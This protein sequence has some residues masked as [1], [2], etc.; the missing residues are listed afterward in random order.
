MSCWRCSNAHVCAC[1]PGLYSSSAPLHGNGHGTACM[2]TAM[3]LPHL[4]QQRPLMATATALPHFAYLDLRREIRAANMDAY[5][6]QTKTQAHKEQ[7]AGSSGRML[8]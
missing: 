8:E 2:A 7:R 6:A 4:F 3:A 1:W 5:C